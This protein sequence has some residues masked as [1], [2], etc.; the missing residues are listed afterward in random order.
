[1]TAGTPSY[2]TA[3]RPPAPF[4]HCPHLTPRLRTFPPINKESGSCR[5]WC[6]MSGSGQGL[7][8]S[9]TVTLV[10]RYYYPD[11][12]NLRLVRGTPVKLV[13][14]P[15]NKVDPCAVEVYVNGTMVSGQRVSHGVTTLAFFYVMTT[16]GY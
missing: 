12:W 14:N 10:G 3:H 7:V 9:R 2:T 4:P 8:D 1:M 16:L 11:S 15:K 5:L 6:T 13:R